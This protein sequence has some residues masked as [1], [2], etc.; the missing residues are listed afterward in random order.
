MPQ[1]P[2]PGSVVS[3]AVG[4]FYGWYVVAALFFTLFLGMGVFMLGRWLERRA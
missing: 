3:R 2:S 4:A 1:T